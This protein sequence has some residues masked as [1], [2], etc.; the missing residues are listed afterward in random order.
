MAS[1]RLCGGAWCRRRALR[2]QQAGHRRRQAA[3]SSPPTSSP[4]RATASRPCP[5]RLWR[6]S[7]QCPARSQV[8]LARKRC[9]GSHDSVPHCH[10]VL[11][12]TETQIR[13][14]QYRCSNMRRPG[15]KPVCLCTGGPEPSA[16]GISG[17]PIPAP[18][19]RPPASAA[20][21]KNGSQPGGEHVLTDALVT[22]RLKQLPAWTCGTR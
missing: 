20:K 21:K 7:A 6:P 12:A 11:L 2:L 17:N 19:G 22:I 3:Q 13:R 9:A 10:R 18:E 8:Q 4:R 1:N 5:P 14:L 16:T 15:E